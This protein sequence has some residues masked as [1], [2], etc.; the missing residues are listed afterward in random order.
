MDETYGQ[1]I[2]Q[3]SEQNAATEFYG[4]GQSSRRRN[5]RRNNNG[6][7]NRLHILKKRNVVIVSGI[8]LIVI[9]SL[10]IP[11]FIYTRDQ[12]LMLSGITISG[13]SVGDL[14]KNEA[15][16]LIDHEIDRLENQ[17]IKLD[18]A[19]KQSL[20][21][22]LKDL[23]LEVTSDAAIENAYEMGR[24]GSLGNKVLTKM[25]ASKGVNF[26]LSHT[27]D[28]KKLKDFLTKS[29]AEYNN[30]AIDASFDITPQNTMSIKGE[31]AGS[32]FD[33][34]ALISQVKKM[35]IYK[36]VNEI[37][38][39]FKEQ[40]PQLTAQQLEDQKITGLL[41]SYT[42]QFDS[43]QAARSDNVRL[44]AKALDKAVIKPG[45]TLS[46]NKIVGERT[47]DGGYKD[48]YIIVNGQFVPGL[49]GGH[50][51]SFQYLV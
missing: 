10:T 45:E 43:S 17:T 8:I 41:S 20:E 2:G 48:A 29:L 9:F 34:D 31:H 4:E 51:P 11:L 16:S 18:A 21:V 3:S 1:R 36:P 30:P 14:S 46:F 12:H 25:S 47:V 28:D 13:I 6:N 49:A 22:K 37:K 38:L 19:G 7:R 32:V 27:W 40:Q 26:E 44:A 15:K 33:Q 5:R 23:G 24:S 42:T 35:D 50:M 39:D